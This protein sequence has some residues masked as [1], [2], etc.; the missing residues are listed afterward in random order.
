MRLLA[1]TVASLIRM[2]LKEAKESAPMITKSIER[3]QKKV[4]E[5]NFGIRKRLLEYDDVMN[6][7]REVIYKRRRHALFGDRLQVDIINNIYDVCEQLIDQHQQDQ[8]FEGLKLACIRSLS[9][10][11]PFTE[12]NLNRDNLKE[13][14]DKLYHQAI[15]AYK[16]K[17]VSI[18]QRVSPVIKNVYE[19]QGQ[20]YENIVIP[21]TDGSKT[22]YIVTTLRKLTSQKA[23]L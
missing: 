15:E 16:R 2:G 10:E 12:E 13:L 3:A 6:N 17:S 19:H 1:R 7:Q 11:V 5:N 8:D 14:T 18:Q 23:G 9:V 22:Y 21:I 20:V 4:E